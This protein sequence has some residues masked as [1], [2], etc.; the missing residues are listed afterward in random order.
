[1]CHIYQLEAYVKG[2]RRDSREMSEGKPIA[3][4]VSSC[5]QQNMFRTG[6][7]ILTDLRQKCG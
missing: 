6:Q 4:P 3:A 2:F 5:L 7:A 1:M